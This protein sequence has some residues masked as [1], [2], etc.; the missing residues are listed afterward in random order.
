MLGAKWRSGKLGVVDLDAFYPKVIECSNQQGYSFLL[1]NETVENPQRLSGG[2]LA[3]ISAVAGTVWGLWGSLSTGYSGMAGREQLLSDLKRMR[4]YC[5]L[6]AIRLNT[7]HVELRL[8]INGDTLSSEAIVGRFALIN[9]RAY[10]FRKYSARIMPGAKM[11][12]YTQGLL[13]FSSHKSAKHFWECVAESCKH[14]AVWKQAITYPW[15]TDLEDEEVKTFSYG[16][17]HFQNREV[18]KLAKALFR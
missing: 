6:I 10:E 2:K 18:E 4:E 16:F 1:P 9:E 15:V 13:L 3:L 5:D 17:G 7:G 8:V 14:R 11:G 12:I